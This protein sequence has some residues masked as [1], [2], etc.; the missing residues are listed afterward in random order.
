MYSVFNNI[1]VN[2]YGESHAPEIGVNLLGIPKGEKISIDEVQKFVDRR[3]G[4]NN[5]WSTARNEEDKVEI[6][7]GLDNGLTNGE[8]IHARI[9]NKDVRS[10][11]YSSIQNT[12]RPSHAD[13]AAYLKDGAP[14]PIPGGGKFS[15]RMTA[16]MCIA[17]GIAKQILKND[18]INVLAYVTKIGNI[19][20]KSYLN[21]NINIEKAYTY[22]IPN[23]DGEAKA[24]EM[25]SE[26]MSARDNLDSVGGVIE[27]VVLN[28]TKGIGD[29]LYDGLEGRIASSIYAIPGVKG[30]EFGAGFALASMKG[31]VA[32]DQ[33]TLNNGKIKLATNNAG[34]INGGISNG[35]PIIV[36]VAI[37]PTPSIARQQNS[38]DLKT[39][40]IKKIEIKGRHDACIVPRAIPVVEAA[41]ALAILDAKMDK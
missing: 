33:F 22:T 37:R 8:E 12:P 32:N 9:Q 41:V 29:A 15:G 14:V 34:G 21:E 36:R 3:K 17:G 24:Q 18:D 28:M 35:E 5:P 6:L 40:E 1:K 20:A 23:L 4:S 26:I 27:C 16:A 19:N 38:V 7:S 10:K 25:V 13:Y 30:V 39:N 31:S 2:I 11:D